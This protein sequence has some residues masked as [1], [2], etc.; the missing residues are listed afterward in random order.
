MFVKKSLCDQLVCLIVFV[1]MTVLCQVPLPNCFLNVCLPTLFAAL[2]KL[3]RPLTSSA[4]SGAA[5]SIESAPAS[6]AAGTTY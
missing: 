3:F 1:G 4:T 6:F 2:L 5:S